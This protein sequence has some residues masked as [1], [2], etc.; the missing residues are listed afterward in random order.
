M[1]NSFPLVR[2]AHALVR[3][4]PAREAVV[5]L[6]CGLFCPRHCSVTEEGSMVSLSSFLRRFHRELQS[7]QLVD[8]SVS[9]LE[10]PEMG[11]TSG[12][13]AL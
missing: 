12:I 3:G 8:S 4:R 11:I 9:G 5:E 10:A 7:L 1:R 2:I 13:E 6:S